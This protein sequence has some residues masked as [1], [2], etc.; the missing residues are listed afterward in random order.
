MKPP[1]PGTEARLDSRAVE[2]HAG[3]EQ[4]PDSGDVE[5]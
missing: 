3:V 2:G 4:P 1:N 5:G